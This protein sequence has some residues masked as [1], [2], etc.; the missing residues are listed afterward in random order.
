MPS[1]FHVE[2]PARA[3]AGA[4]AVPADPDHSP[5]VLVGG[6]FVGIGGGVSA[7]GALGLLAITSATLDWFAILFTGQ[8]IAGLQRVQ[9]P[10]PRWRARVMAYACFLRDEYPPFGDGRLSG[11]AGAARR[12]ADARLQ[13]GAAAAALADART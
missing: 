9:A 4:R 5:R 12:A 6:P 13:V 7:T 2:P 1:H 10:V 8:S 11:R 3:I